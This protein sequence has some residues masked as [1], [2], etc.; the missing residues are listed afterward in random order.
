MRKNEAMLDF[1]T[2]DL[3]SFCVGIILL[4]GI[5]GN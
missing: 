5:G 1:S 4:D 2:L 3:H